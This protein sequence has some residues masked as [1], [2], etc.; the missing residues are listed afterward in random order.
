MTKEYNKKEEEKIRKLLKSLTRRN[1]FFAGGV[2][3]YVDGRLSVTQ[4]R[5]SKNT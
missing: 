5:K 4:T 2:I 3:A 1:T